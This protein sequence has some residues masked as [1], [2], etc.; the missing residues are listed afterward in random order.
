MA[1]LS[2]HVDMW[3]LDVFVSVIE[4]GS[5]SKAA[6]AHRLSQ[7]AVSTRVANLERLLGVRLLD[8]GAG[9]S[10][11]TEA[12]VV[13]A[14]WSR[15]T[16]DA[17]AQLLAGAD[18]LQSQAGQRL[19]LAASFTVAEFLLPTW[20]HEFLEKH[21]DV[22]AAVDVTNSK[23]VLERLSAREVEVGFVEGR[24]VPDEL[25]S[26]TVATDVLVVVV[27]KGH[28]WA[29]RS[30]VSPS[31]IADTPLVLREEGSGTREVLDA[32]LAAAGCPR[33]CSPAVE[34]GS[35][36]AGKHAVIDGAGPAVLSSL[37]V[38]VERDAGRLVVVDV[39]GL[40]VERSLRA[41]WRGDSP[42]TKSATAFLR[43]LGAIP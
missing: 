32:A 4:L 21:P 31:E 6:A 29:E 39:S 28:P 7:P 18:E 14:G 20:L 9:G 25:T 35:T 12:G 11:P 33:R 17:A 34:L 43:Q 27:P 36:T 38:T 41:V 10:R 26:T 16:L 8:R 2:R 37:A 30:A 23:R 22:S 5:I 3:S 24:H 19:Q 42:T 13:V 40:A 15:T 1:I